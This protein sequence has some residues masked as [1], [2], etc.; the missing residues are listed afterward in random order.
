[1]DRID[2]YRFRIIW[3]LANQRETTNQFKEN[4][5]KYQFIK[6]QGQTNEEN[7]YRLER[8]F[9]YDD[10]IKIIRKQVERYEDLVKEQ[11]EMVERAKHNTFDVQSLQNQVKTI[12]GRR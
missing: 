3:S 6:M 2:N 5:L 1:M 9:Q 11:A 12:K 4:D 8:Q 7:I 10:S